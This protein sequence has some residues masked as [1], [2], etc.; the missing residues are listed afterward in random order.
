VPRLEDSLSRVFSFLVEA[1]EVIAVDLL[2]EA[3]LDPEL[4]AGTVSR[5]VTVSTSATVT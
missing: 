3:V 4:V 2:V 5:P 1:F